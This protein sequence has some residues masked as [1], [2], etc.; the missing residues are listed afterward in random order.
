MSVFTW[1]PQGQVEHATSINN[2]TLYE[3]NYFYVQ[4]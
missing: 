3:I 1:T 4:K 2:M